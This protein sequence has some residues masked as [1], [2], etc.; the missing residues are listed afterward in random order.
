MQGSNQD[1]TFRIDALFSV[2]FGDG[3]LMVPGCGSCQYYN[4]RVSDKSKKL[5]VAGSAIRGTYQAAS[6]FLSL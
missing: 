3:P 4:I 6:D 2:R 5:S 1:N